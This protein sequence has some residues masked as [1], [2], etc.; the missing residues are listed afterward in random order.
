MLKRLITGILFCLLVGTA[1]VSAQ[2]GGSSLQAWADTHTSAFD[3]TQQIEWPRYERTF[4]DIEAYN[5]NDS[6]TPSCSSGHSHS[7]WLTFV[8]PQTGKITIGTLG[9]NFT[10][11]TAVYKNTPTVAN[12]IGCLNATSVGLIVTD[13]N[14]KAG[15]RYYML[16]AA[17]GTGTGVDASSELTQIFI[18]NYKSENAFQISPSGVYTNIQGYIETASP[19]Y[20]PAGTCGDFNLM[21]YYKFRPTVSGRYEFSTNGSGYDTLIHLQDGAS[22]S[23]CNDNI[24]VDNHNS[25][26]RPTLVAGTLYYLVIG[27]S[28]LASPELNEDL[29]LSLRVRKL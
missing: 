25:R 6:V 2:D 3:V 24:N 19:T 1:A 10:T 11:V 14:I 28:D 22:L 4:A 27:Q 29:V 23:V 17:T 7:L 18:A 20:A 8:A 9:S 12:E 16:L 5:S 15:T 13:I 26:I 21:V